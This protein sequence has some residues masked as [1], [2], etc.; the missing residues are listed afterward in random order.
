MDELV[1]QIGVGGIFAILLIQMVLRFVTDF[2][3]SKESGVPEPIKVAQTGPQAIVNGNTPN[4]D[5]RIEDIHEIVGR[6]DDDGVPRVYVPK[7]W[8]RLLEE[9]V[10]L[11]REQENTNER[12]LGALEQN[13]KVLR[14]LRD[15]LAD[16][17]NKPRPIDSGHHPVARKAGS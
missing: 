17:Q 14:Q 9:V 8:G 12:M 1:T 4:P 2:T 10:A 15:A 5:R 13:T 6:V 3:K 7:A 11:Q 16:L